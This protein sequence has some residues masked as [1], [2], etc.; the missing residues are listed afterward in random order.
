MSTFSRGSRAKAVVRHEPQALVP[1]VVRKGELLTVGRED[2]EW[3]GWRW[4]TAA[5]GVAG[6]I[7]QTYLIIHGDKGAATCEYDATELLLERDEL[8][9]VEKEVNGWVWCSSDDG[10]RG[11]TPTRN[12]APC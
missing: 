7:P 8:L 6:W 2:D 11:W 1:I 10:R 12:L 4:C 5:N 9:T 3:P